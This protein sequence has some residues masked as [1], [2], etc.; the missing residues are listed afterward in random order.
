MPRLLPLLLVILLLGG[1]L[2]YLSTVPEAQPT[3][4]IEVPVEQGGNAS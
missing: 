3:H 4:T 1:A 2:Y